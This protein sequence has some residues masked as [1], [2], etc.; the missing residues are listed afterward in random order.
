MEK[1]RKKI[2]WTK[3]AKKD[4]KVIY[5]YISEFSLLSADILIDKLTVKSTVL[6]YEGC[7]DIG[8]VDE[9]NPKIQAIN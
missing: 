5:D 3:S 2:K 6:S 7:S 4:L 8:S 1:E 9:C